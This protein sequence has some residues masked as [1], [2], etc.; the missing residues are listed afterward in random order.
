MKY[1]RR[2]K[3]EYS[4]YDLNGDLTY[5]D[6][7]NLVNYVSADIPASYKK[8]ILNLAN[9]SYINSSAHIKLMELQKILKGKKIPLYLMNVSADIMMLMEIRGFHHLFDIISD[10]QNIIEEVRKSEISEMLEKNIS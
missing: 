6:S 8:L 3:G 5:K 1:T 9:V 7:V 10:E 2:M 4:I